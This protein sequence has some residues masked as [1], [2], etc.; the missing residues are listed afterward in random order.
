[1][2]IRAIL[3]F[4]VIF[5]QPLNSAAVYCWIRTQSFTTIIFVLTEF[6]TAENV[7]CVH[8]KQ[9]ITYCAK[10]LQFDWLQGMQLIRNCTGEIR[11][12]TC[13][14]DL[15]GY[16]CRAKTCNSPRLDNFGCWWLDC[17]WFSNTEFDFLCCVHMLLQSDA[18]TLRLCH[19]CVWLVQEIFCIYWQNLPCLQTDFKMKDTLFY[20]WI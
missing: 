20:Q 6:I 14:C 11:A 16:F 19:W 3:I 9:L 1:M 13:N 8:S 7:S 17:F 2:E 4:R 12:K 15:I 10:V 5:D 18:I